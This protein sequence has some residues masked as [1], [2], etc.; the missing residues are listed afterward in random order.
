LDDELLA[1][2]ESVGI[3]NGLFMRES[4]KEVLAVRQLVGF[5]KG[6]SVGK[7]VGFNERL[8][9]GESDEELSMGESVNKASMR[10]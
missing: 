8:A 2:G 10:G 9:M 6:L 4:D 1:V 3:V 7:L 5:D